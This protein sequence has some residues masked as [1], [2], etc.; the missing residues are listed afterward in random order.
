MM[1]KDFIHWFT[2]L[3][4][5]SGA[6]EI[7]YSEGDE[8]LRI[9]CAVSPG[10]APARLPGSAI[11]DQVQPCVEKPLPAATLHEI[12]SGVTATFFRSA[13]PDADPFV[14]VGDVIEEGQTLG[15]LEAMKMLTPLEAD[16]GGTI[17]EI[18]VTDGA[19]INAGTV[20]LTLDPS[21]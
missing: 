6:A 5:Q 17:V 10:A 12:R 16:R 19:T 11:I 3:A 1:D 14:Q 20:I 18:K 13:S 21:T 15:L 7:E 2:T 4:M 8:S 9:V